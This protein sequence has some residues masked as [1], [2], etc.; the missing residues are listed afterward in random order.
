[1]F[2]LAVFSACVSPRVVTKPGVD[3]SRIRSIVLLESDRQTE[4]S[5]IDEFARQ[6][7][8]RGYSVQVRPR[9]G[10][11]T[12]AVLQVNIAQLTPDKKYLVQLDK[13]DGGKDRDVL[14]LHPVTEISGRT[15]Y[16]SASVSGLED[17]QIMISN[18]T[19][20]L[21]ARLMDPASREILWSA[22]ATYEGLDLDAAVEGAVGS[23][24]KKFPSR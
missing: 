9:G 19:V 14:V 18:A 24:M 16:P 15:V 13:K 6:L 12:D 2:F 23:L 3:F 20:S 8:L 17:A 4:R 5:V 22:A 11:K 1:L 7:I 10:T 21:S